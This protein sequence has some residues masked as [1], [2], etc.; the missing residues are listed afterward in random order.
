MPPQVYLPDPKACV[1]SLA[2]IFPSAGRQG[3]RRN[4]ISPPNVSVVLGAVLST[5]TVI[6]NWQMF[7]SLNLKSERDL[8]IN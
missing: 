4:S 1:L 6:R 8:K 7:V 2:E 3:Q 5:Q